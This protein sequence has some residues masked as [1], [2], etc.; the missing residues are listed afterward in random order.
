MFGI[1][2]RYVRNANTLSAGLHAAASRPVCLG[3]KALEHAALY[4]GGPPLIT[5]KAKQLN[6][7]VY[8]DN[9]TAD[10]YRTQ[11]K[12][13]EKAAAFMQFLVNSPKQAKFYFWHDSVV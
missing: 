10:R 13:L 11:E 1:D 2:S 7:I 3:A 4:A 8:C 5:H 9:E 12:L 6:G